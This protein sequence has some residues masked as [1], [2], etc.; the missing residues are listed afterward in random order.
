ML[1]DATGYAHWNVPA[2]PVIQMVCPRRVLIFLV[3]AL[4][5]LG[6]PEGAIIADYVCD[7]RLSWSGL[8]VSLRRA[9]F[10]DVYPPASGP[11]DIEVTEF[12][13]DGAVKIMLDVLTAA[14]LDLTP[15]DA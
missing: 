2:C 11:N 4:T 6:T 12:S 7:N 8:S 14:T 5:M 3:K 1:V 10:D 13:G 15:L 9:W